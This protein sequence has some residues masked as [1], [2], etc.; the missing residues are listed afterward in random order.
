MQAVKNCNGGTEEGTLEK[1]NPHLLVIKRFGEPMPPRVH[2]IR[3][4]KKERKGEKGEEREREGGEGER[5]GEGEERGRSE[6]K[7]GVRR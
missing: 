6:R 3:P 2:H 7:R 5:R 1:E 4:E